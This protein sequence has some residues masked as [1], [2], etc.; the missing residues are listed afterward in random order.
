MTFEAPS[1]GKVTPG[2]E[3]T[4]DQGAEELPGAERGGLEGFLDLETL[5][6]SLDG[7]IYMG[8]HEA[9]KRKG[10]PGRKESLCESTD[11]KQGKGDVHG[12]KERGQKSD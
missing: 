8:F 12:G 5:Q 4:R 7:H 11:V 1:C 6:V 3:P 2:C 9:Q 10:T